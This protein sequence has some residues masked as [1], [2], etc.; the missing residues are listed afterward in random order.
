MS[1]KPKVPPKP[2]GQISASMVQFTYRVTQ[3]QVTT[4]VPKLVRGVV[5]GIRMTAEF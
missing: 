2:N 3:H 1:Q 4:K 5:G